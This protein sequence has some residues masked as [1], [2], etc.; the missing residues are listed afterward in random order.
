MQDFSEKGFAGARVRDI[1]ERAGVSKDL[2]AYH[3]GGKEGLYRA[4]QR[5]WLHRRDGFA[6][7]GLPLAESLARYLHDALSDPR[8]MRLLAWRGLRH[9]L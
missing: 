1:A 2:I 9:R 7:P 4:V 5:A 3:F 8:P 6:E